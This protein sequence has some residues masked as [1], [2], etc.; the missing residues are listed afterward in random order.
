M[1]KKEF[2]DMM[3]DDEELQELRR[4]VYSVTGQLKD[5]SFRIGANYTYEE[6]K[7]QLRKIVEEHETTSQ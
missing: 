2:V 3:R 7:E 6:W 5:I 4:K 1:L